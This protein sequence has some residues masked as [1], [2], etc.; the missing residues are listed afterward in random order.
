MNTKLAETWKT[1]RV[2]PDAEGLMARREDYGSA[3]P[4]E[5]A[6]LTCGIDVQDDRLELE[7]CRLGP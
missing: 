5:V 3:V 4:A 7:R 2:R 1:G 6:L